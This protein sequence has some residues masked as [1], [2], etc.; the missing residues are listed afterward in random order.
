LAVVY[1]ALL[2]ERFPRLIGY[3]NANSDVASAYV[4][5][6]AVSRGH[7]GHVVLGT[8]GMWVPLWFGLL[9]HGLSFHRVL[10]EI[11]PALLLLAAAALIGWTVARLASASAGLLATALIV[12]A[13][14]TALVDFS[15]PAYHNVIVPGAAV[16]GAYLVWLTQREH[17]LRA[18]IVSGVALSLLVGT[19]LASDE[20]LA[21]VGLVPFLAAAVVIHLRAGRPPWLYPVIGVLAGSV[22]VAVITSLAMSGLGFSDNPPPIALTRRLIPEHIKWLVQ[23]LL[24]FGNGLSV[25][26]H[27]SARTALVVAAA[28]ATAAGVAAGAW[29]GAR[30][31][32]S[33]RWLRGS[34]ALAAHTL[35]WASSLLCAAAAYVVST[36]ASYP[37]TERYFLVAIPA[38]AATASLVSRR[39][40]ARLAVAAGAS[41]VIAASIVSLV[42][43]DERYVIFQGPDSSQAARI[44]ALVRSQHLGIGYG[45]YWDAA[46]LDWITHERLRVY[47]L[48]DR[49]GP[50]EPMYENRAAA[51][52][53]PRPHTPSYLLLAPGDDN[54]ANAIPPSL[55]A[56]A[57]ELHLGSVTVAVY[58]YDIA[59][60]L[61]PP[62]NGS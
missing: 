12:A 3:Q 11:S 24:H 58:P 5:A 6:D 57:R 33:P 52:Y 53:V 56:P 28:V 10:W 37:Q 54:L 47:P 13:S 7:T 44:Q 17:S 23:G 22:V 40:G 16:L 43:G 48:T 60:Y 30:S 15:A 61:H 34:P 21:A 26:P 46:D 18:H 49:F 55:P 29:L 27:S 9:T 32:A 50:L 36:F 51:W 25:A 8:Q 45:G 59:R 2:V 4:L 42:A 31:L 20:L 19:F 38:V 41:L 35:F 62:R 1:L 14:P 39:G